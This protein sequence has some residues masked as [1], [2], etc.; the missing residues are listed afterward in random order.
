LN[1]TKT[2]HKDIDIQIMATATRIKELKRASDEE[3]KIE[4]TEW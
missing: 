1:P 3:D 2:L 4:Q